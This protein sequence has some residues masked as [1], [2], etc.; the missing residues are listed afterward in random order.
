[1]P[2]SYLLF[3]HF[4]NVSEQARGLEEVLL[5]TLGRGQLRSR[6]EIIRFFD[7]FDLVEPGLVHLPEWRPDEPVKY[8]LDISELLYLGGL[9][10]KL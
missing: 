9:A 4:S 6:E 10:R 2:G 7:G 1:M 3:T 8:P 5:R